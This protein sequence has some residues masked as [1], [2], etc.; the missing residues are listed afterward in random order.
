MTHPLKYVTVKGNVS[1]FIPDGMDPDDDPDELGVTG[2]VR[3][4]LQLNSKDAVLMPHHPKG[5]TIRIVEPFDVQL[6]S[7]GDLSH[8]GKKFVKLPALDQWTNPQVARYRVEFVDLRVRG[9]RVVLR[10]LEIPAVPDTVV[11]LANEF[12]VPGSPAPGVS[13]GEKGDS[14]VAVRVV[15]N[16]L[17]FEMSDGGDLPPVSLQA[18]ADLGEAADA[19]RASELSAGVSAATAVEKAGEAV[20]ARN[21]SLDGAAVAATSA[22]VAQ[23]K[24]AEAVAAREDSLDGATVAVTSAEVAQLKAAEASAARDD[25]LDGAAVATTAAE[26]ADQSKQVAVAKAGEAQA[27]AG[28]AT[29]KAGEAAASAAAALASE[30]A[31]AGWAGA[32]ADGSVSTVKLQD[33]AVTLGKLGAS[34]VDSSKIVD[35]SIAA[36]DLQ[37]GAVTNSKLGFGSVSSDKLA[38]SAVTTDKLANGNVTRDKLVTALKDSV[39]RADSAYQKPAAGIPGSDVAANAGIDFTKLAGVPFEV[40][41]VHSSGTRKAG[42]GDLIVH[43]PVTR[44]CT[45]DSVLFQFGTRDSSGSTSVSLLRN[46]SLI[47]GTNLSV[48]AANQVDGTGTDGA[49]TATATGNNVLV[50]NDRLGVNVTALGATPGKVLVAVIRGRYT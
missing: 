29:T 5:P 11:D 47:T 48:A 21:D 38:S 1:A 46:G 23:S 22:E 27:A 17:Q 19:A 36:V 34:S 24:A 42:T 50:Q 18:L 14:V 6:D 16:S 45:I 7:N 4:T 37:D 9:N 13:R 33:G 40:V 49:R 32:P 12:P 10:P 30:Q 43:M 8:R 35:G 20:A 25:S 26:S 3:F 15:G 39:D 2:S 31:A 44:A 28:T 41:I